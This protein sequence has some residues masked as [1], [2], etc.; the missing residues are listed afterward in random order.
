MDS[1]PIRYRD[2][3]GRRQME[4]GRWTQ[5]QSGKKLQIETIERSEEESENLKQKRERERKVAVCFLP[6]SPPSETRR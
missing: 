4:K 1:E 2:G 3:H 5:R 6:P